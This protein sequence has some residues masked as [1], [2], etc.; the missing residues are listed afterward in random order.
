VLKLGAIVLCLVVLVVLPFL[1]WGETLEAY[2]TGDGAVEALRGYGAAAGLV[3]VGLLVADLL[4]PIPTTAVMAALGIIYGPVVGGLIAAAGSFLSGM[5]GYG[6]C[7]QFG[8]P[9][10]RWLM[11][12]GALEEGERIFARFGGWIV[13]ASRWLPVLPEVVSG[14]AGL[15][16]MAPVPY[17]AALLCGA[18][19]VGFSFALVGHLG[20]GTPVTTL[21]VCAVA[22]LVL[23]ALVRPGLRR[24]TAG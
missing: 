24:I 1:L 10:A 17:M 15:S 20:A 23:W 2:F 6:V 13:A 7:R 22:P 8:R 9:V 14:L 12:P 21:V 4:L 5:V 11:G 18:V 3:A 16:R 19:P